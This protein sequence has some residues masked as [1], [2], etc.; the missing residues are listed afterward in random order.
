MK[1]II[2]WLVIG[3]VVILIVGVVAVGLSLDKIVKAGIETAGPRITQTTLTVDS[4]NLS[5]LSGS[6]GI[7]G[8]VLGNP[9]GFT[10]PQAIS[11]GKAAV[12]IVPGSILADKVIIHSVEVRDADITFEGNPFGAN[13][14]T[15]IMENVNSLAGA[16]NTNTP[17]ANSPATGSSKPAKKLEVDDFLITGAKVHASIT[18]IPGLGTKE[19]TVPIPEIHFTDLGKGND[20]ITA[21]ELTQKILSA[22]TASTVTALTSSVADLGGN[23][24]GAAKNIL[25]GVTTNGANAV[26]AGVD[27]V[28]KG[29]GGLFG[30]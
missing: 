29:L 14:F 21:G 27:A 20:G 28:K 5:L 3:V 2:L 13:N 22:I 23:V 15:K 18:G 19:I 7:N 4:V 17:A 8:L 16:P 1:K 24:T 9:P 26:G 6:A 12:S 11:L 30:K 10:S 25:S